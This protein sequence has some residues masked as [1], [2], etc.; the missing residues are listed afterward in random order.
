[1]AVERRA[2]VMAMAISWTRGCDDDALRRRTARVSG[3]GHRW[4]TPRRLKVERRIGDSG[5][6][7]ADK[8]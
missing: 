8:G 2:S 3:G 4:K 6:A 1:M 7:V 5:A